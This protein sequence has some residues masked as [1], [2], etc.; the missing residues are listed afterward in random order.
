MVAWLIRLGTALLSGKQS[1]AVRAG[2]AVAAGA[3]TSIFV[4]K[5][6]PQSFRRGKC[7]GDIAAGASSTLLF[8]CPAF[9]M[10]PGRPRWLRPGQASPVLFLEPCPDRQTDPAPWWLGWNLPRA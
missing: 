2:A 5:L 4:Y 9:L 6:A 3:V 1:S 7:A 10:T 8:F